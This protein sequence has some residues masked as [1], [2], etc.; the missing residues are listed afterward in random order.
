ML[1]QWVQTS[2]TNNDTVECIAVSGSNLYAGTYDGGCLLLSTN[3][4]ASCA[5]IN[6][7]LTTD[8]IGAV[9]VLGTNL[10]AAAHDGVYVSTNEGTSWKYTGLA[11]DDAAAFAVC[12]MNLFAGTISAGVLLSTNNGA[13]WTTVNNGLTN[14]GVRALAVIDTNLFA[15]TW[16]GVFISTNNGTSWTEGSTVLSIHVLSLAVCGANLFAGTDGGVFLSTNNGASW[17]K[18]N[19]GL[20]NN[21]VNALAVFG[22]NLFAGTRGGVFLSTNSGTTW[23]AVNTGLTNTDISALAISDTILFAGTYGGGICRRPLSEMITAVKGNYNSMT[24]SF[25]LKQNYPNPFNPSTLISYQ[26]PTNSIVSLRVYNVLG[27]EVETLVS[28]R[29]TA[30]THS[31]TFNAGSLPSG[32]YFYRLEAGTYHDTKKLLLVK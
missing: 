4:G 8:P 20:T 21:Y 31:V 25:V 27:R 29:Q 19:T 15:G 26:L 11:Y 32:V 23:T 17:T 9:F 7:G 13:S 28:D 16:G 3:N 14:T 6:I 12:G 18:V 22:I 10:F 24:Q 5:G 2:G 1:A 30:G